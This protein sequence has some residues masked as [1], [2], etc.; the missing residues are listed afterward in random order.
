MPLVSISRWI[1][2]ERVKVD[3]GPGSEGAEYSSTIAIVEADYRVAGGGDMAVVICI[4][5][6]G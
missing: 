6:N 5:R 1:L 3:E 4:E 2:D